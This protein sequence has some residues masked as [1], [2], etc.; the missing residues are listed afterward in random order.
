MIEKLT[1]Q[2]KNLFTKEPSMEETHGDTSYMRKILGSVGPGKGLKKKTIWLASA[3]AALLLA[4]AVVLYASTGGSQTRYKTAEVKKGD[5][6][7]T[8]TATGTLQPVEQV[9]VGTEVSGTIKTVLVDYN[10]KVKQGQVLAKLDT[11][12][13]E[14]QVL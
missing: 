9:E 14:A 2:T 6:T 12:K 13:L 8:V 5:L 10:Y 1:S 7:V 11:T 3:A 4:G